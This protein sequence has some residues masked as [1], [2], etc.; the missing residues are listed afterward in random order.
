[1]CHGGPPAGKTGA[2][3]GACQRSVPM[4]SNVRYVG[5]DVHKRVVEAC[6]LDAA[7]KELDRYRFDLDRETLLHFAK[8]RLTPHDHV[9][10]E[11]TTNCW[12]VARFLT[13]FVA[14]LVVSNP[15]VTKAIAEAKVKTDKVDALVL[16]Q[17]LRCDFLP[18]VWQP[19][20]EIQEQRRLSSRRGSLVSQRIGIKN[21]L[22]SVLAQ[23]LIRPSVSDLFNAKGKAWLTHLE[24]DAEGREA[25]DSDL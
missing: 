7:G 17:L 6:F 14:E 10:L 1:M 13:P 5:L 23:R 16:A 25:I 21:R 4:T 24:L 2:A 12:V 9:A 20:A 19:P 15:L 22:H 18:R 11:A 3:L 8:T